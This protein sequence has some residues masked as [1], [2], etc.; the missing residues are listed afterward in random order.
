[1]INETI[2]NTVAVTG[3]SFWTDL[4]KALLTPTSLIIALLVFRTPIDKFFKN[5]KTW[6]TLRKL[7]KKYNRHIIMLK[8]GSVGI[9]SDM[10]A[11][12]TL[13]GFISAFS[14]IK[15]GDIDLIITSGGG[16]V[17]HSMRIAKMLSNYSKG[18][19]RAII[20]NYAMSGASMLTL[21]CDEIIIDKNACLGVIDPQLGTFFE[22]HSS[23]AWEEIVKHKGKKAQ[24]KSVANAFSGKQVT[25]TIRNIIKELIKDKIHPQKIERFLD[26][27]VKGNV[28][29]SYQL[30]YSILKENGL[31]VTLLEDRLY[32]RILLCNNYKEVICYSKD[33]SL[34]GAFR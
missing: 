29:H 1:M 9:F 26:L 18:K 16:A 14:K 6:I 23:R 5:L 32:K 22:T 28:E 21:A 30:D 27:L 2:I 3:T 13:T 12:G 7:S 19:I 15:Q 31:P 4:I 17:F 33:Y 8:H 34:G 25:K 10:I 20:P 11:G 24:D